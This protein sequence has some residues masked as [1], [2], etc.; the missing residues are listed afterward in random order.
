MPFSQSSELSGEPC[1]PLRGRCML[2]PSSRR[3]ILQPPELSLSACVPLFELADYPFQSLDL[4]GDVAEL[5]F[6]A[7][8]QPRVVRSPAPSALQVQ[9]RPLGAQGLGPQSLRT[10]LQAPARVLRP[11][12]PAF[13]FLLLRFET[14][15]LLSQ[16][17]M[18]GPQG[19]C[20]VFELR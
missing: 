10:V 6:E 4:R 19:G 9:Q 2:R 16:S 17:L 15:F 20:L 13:E 14:S 12:Y 11:P 18:P 1:S 7:L 5:G 8:D 3:E